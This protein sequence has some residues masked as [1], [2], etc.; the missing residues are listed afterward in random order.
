MNKPVGLVGL[1]NLGNTCFLNSCLQVLNQIPELHSILETATPKVLDSPD[2]IMLK[3]WLE[4]KNIMWSGNGSLSPNKFVHMVQQVAA[5][6]QRELFTGWAQNDITEFLLFLIECFHNSISHKAKIQINGKPENQTDQRAIICYELIQS[7]YAKEYSKILELFYG[8]Y[9]T[10][11]IDSEII[12]S[13]IIAP[14][15]QSVLSTKA[16]H[17]FVL[18]LQIFYNNTV[19]NNLYDCFNLFIM[20][21]LMTG[22]NAWFNDKTGQKQPVNRQVNFWNFPD[23]LVITLK[24]F[25]PDGVRKLQHLVDFPLEDLDLSKYAK[26]Y[27]S[28]KNVYDLFGVCNHSGGVLGGHYTAFVKNSQDVWYHYNDQMIELINNPQ[29]VVS[30]AAY[31]LFYRKKI[32]YCNI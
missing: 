30:P 29:S 1:V 4:L 32:P 17:Y 16:E 21:E 24:R 3:E 13:E 31:C 23:I 20:P 9:M 6:K 19:C 11:I 18:D 2:T 27:Q 5:I 14:N 12:D 7:I 26:G 28:S 25:S 8:I 22:E 10:E 15:N